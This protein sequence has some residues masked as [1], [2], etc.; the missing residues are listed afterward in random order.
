MY[1]RRESITLSPKPDVLKA[2]ASHEAGHAMA[3]WHLKIPFGRG[4]HA[5][6]IVPD[7]MAQGHFISKFILRGRSLDVSTTDA[8]R[9]KME[10]VVVVRL[11]G[12][13]AQQRFKP[14]SVRNWHGSSDY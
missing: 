5:L 8:D 2:T 9:L 11:A 13:V 4:K 12:L 1:G 14:S 7:D 3:A 6:S 10:R